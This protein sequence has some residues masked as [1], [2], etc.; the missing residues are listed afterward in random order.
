MSY[1]IGPA[2]GRGCLPAALPETG[3]GAAA[4]HHHLSP[5]LCIYVSSPLPSTSAGLSDLSGNEPSPDP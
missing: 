3:F 1:V 2:D 5:L 4:D